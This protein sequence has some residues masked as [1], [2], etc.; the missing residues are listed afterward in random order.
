[1]KIGASTYSL[2]KAT[3]AGTFDLMGMFEWLADNGAEH[4]EIVPR[5][6]LFWF[7]DSPEIVPTM[8]TKAKEVDL[9]ISC[10]T[11]GASFIDLTLEEFDAEVDRVKGEI[12]HAAGLGVQLVRH[13][14]A[15]RPADQASDEQFDKDLP[16][17]VDVCGQLADYAATKGITT[18]IENHGFHVQ[19][20]K[21]V[22]RIHEGVARDNFKLLIDTGNFFAVEFDNTLNAIKQC[23]PFAGMV[24]TKDHH[25]RKGS[26]EPADAWRDRGNGIYTQAAIAAD[27]DIGI[28]Q[29]IGYLK[30]AGYDGYLSLEYEG[31]EEACYANK[32]GMENL[33]R[34][35][36]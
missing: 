7:A 6:E 13:D 33:R 20:A 3:Q 31:P 19:G 12:D 30:D 28:E 4:I 1:M 23:A 29:A 34:I 16:L 25:I 27:G 26:Q 9:D 2:Y 24:H 15:F 10:Y 11:F 18:M 35:L 8:A 36:G 14:V 17:F 22:L 5:R 21:R 32:K